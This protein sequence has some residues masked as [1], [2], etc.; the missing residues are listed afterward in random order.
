MAVHPG[1][2]LKRELELRSLGLNDLAGG[3]GLSLEQIDAIIAGR[4]AVDAA[5]A[6][7]LG[8]FFGHSAKFWTALQGAYD[9][10]SGRASE[11]S[12]PDG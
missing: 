1:A 6:A 7:V 5:I 8:R 2:V 10:R 12:R 4:S 9:E 3:T 11:S